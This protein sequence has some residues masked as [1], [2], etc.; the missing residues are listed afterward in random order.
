MLGVLMGDSP[1]QTV[2]SNRDLWG[3]LRRADEAALT[4]LFHLVWAVTR[5]RL[6]RPSGVRTAYPGSAHRD[7]PACR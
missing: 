5:E 3:R 1:G 7:A 2:R 4:A 6:G